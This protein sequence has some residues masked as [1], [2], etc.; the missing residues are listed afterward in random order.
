MFVI[1]E[2][3]GIENNDK[4]IEKFIKSKIKNLSKLEK[5]SKFKKLSSIRICFYFFKTSFYQYLD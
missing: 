5:L 1:N 3:D 4:L 2:V